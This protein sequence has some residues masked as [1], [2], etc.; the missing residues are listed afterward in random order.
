MAKD[1]DQFK[2]SITETAD[3]SQER[4]A[5]IS[6]VSRTINQMRKNVQQEIDETQTE[7]KEFESVSK[8]EHSMNSVLL[9]LNR[10]V[11]VIGEGFAKVAMNTAKA[12]GDLLKGYGKAITQ[13]INLNK[14]NVVAMALSRT[15]PIFGYFAAKFMETD[16]YQKAKERMK[17]AFSNMFSSVTSKLKEGLSGLFNKLRFSKKGKGGVRTDTIEEVP[18]MQKGGIVERAGMAMLHPAEVVMPI[19]KL[20]SRIDEAISVSKEV[21][22]IA[23]KTQLQ[24]LAKVAGYVDDTRKWQKVGIFRGFLQAMRMVQTRYEEPANM[25]MLRA[26]LSIQSAMGATVG[27]WPQVWQKM[28]IQHPFFRN[29]VFFSRSLYK[30]FT[31]PFRAVYKVFKTRGGYLSQLSTAKNPMEAAAENTGLAYAE[32]MWRLDNI[33]LYTKATAEAVRDL[34]SAFTGKKYAPIEGIKTGFWSVFGWFRDLANTIVKWLPAILGPIFLGKAG[35]WKEGKSLGE[36]L[37]QDIK[38]A[39]LPLTKQREKLFGGLGGAEQEQLSFGFGKEK[40][41]YVVDINFE[42]LFGHIKASMIARGKQMKKLV[43]ASEDTSKSV[44]ETEKIN[45]EMNRRQKVQAFLGHMKIFSI[46]APAFAMVADTVIGLFRAK[47]WDLSRTE[48]ALVGFLGGNT[49]G[50]VGA[51]IGAL[52][53]GLIGLRFGGPTGMVVG[54]AI[55]GGL[56]YVGGEE[57]ARQYVKYK[58]AVFG[59]LAEK[60]GLDG[61]EKNSL[62]AAAALIGGTGSGIDGALTG[63]IKGGI[64]GFLVSGFNPVGALVGAAIGGGLG[65]IGGEAMASSWQN[66]T[67]YIRKILRV[68]DPADVQAQQEMSRQYEMKNVEKRIETLKA[69]I[70][71]RS[72][73]GQ[74]TEHLEKKLEEEERY[75]R[76]YMT[77]SGVGTPVMSR[78]DAF[79][80]ARGEPEYSLPTTEGIKE[81]G[82]AEEKSFWSRMFD[83]MKKRHQRGQEEVEGI[84]SEIANVGKVTSEGSKNQVQATIL[85]TTSLNNTINNNIG[86]GGSYDDSYRKNTPLQLS[87]MHGEISP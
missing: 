2:G 68:P 63:A 61:P 45:K 79:S 31:L 83:A 49:K 16:V 22:T 26:V 73:M 62:A 52:K 60:W 43:G 33:I 48:A 59:G 44:K 47:E 77:Q 17:T 28:L 14:Q 71:K 1:N 8:I 42:K 84:I 58:E 69:Q 74:S 72:G 75:R 18:K 12:S 67:K 82:P 38:T 19:D 55:G 57:L 85:S 34:A 65:Y 9:K 4:I 50:K 36:F 86:R 23:K 37:T 13:D 78:Y 51:Y 29:V 7:V 6:N 54:A 56:G 40:P 10:T 41:F 66:A 3:S 25:R 21:A 11:G 27:T 35:G 30:F 5:E 81:V 32:G 64:F 39:I 53:G 80:R 87:L 15:T 20:L 24:S 76:E 70:K 46:L